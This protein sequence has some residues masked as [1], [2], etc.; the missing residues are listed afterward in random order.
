MDGD[1]SS[2][3]MVG[4]KGSGKGGAASGKPWA[5]YR[6]AAGRLGSSISVGGRWN[7]TLA[8]KRGPLRPQ[9]SMLTCLKRVGAS[10]R[11]YQT[12]GASNSAAHFEHWD[13]GSGFFVSFLDLGFDFFVH[14]SPGLVFGSCKPSVCN[15]QFCYPILPSMPCVLKA[16]CVIFARGLFLVSWHV[17]SHIH[18]SNSAGMFLCP[19]SDLCP[20]AGIFLLS[21]FLQAVKK[22]NLYMLSCN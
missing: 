17:L 1:S 21:F 20:N 22:V 15:F 10:G 5:A 16:M 3:G 9:I 6:P 11:K 13:L 18:F 4:P 2:F 12:P 8:I 19:H 14:L 7:Q